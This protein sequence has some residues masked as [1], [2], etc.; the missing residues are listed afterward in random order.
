[1]LA[2]AFPI[3]PNGGTI[4]LKL[5]ITAPLDLVSASEGRLALPAILDRNFS[6]GGGAPHALWIESK[7]PVTT[8]VPGLAAE[9]A[10][11]GAHRLAGT[12]SDGALSATRAI[13]S[14]TRDPAANVRVARIG[15]K[16]EVRQEIATTTATLAALMLVVD[17]SQ[18][19]QSHIAG[20][21]AA[22]EA[23]PAGRPVGL[24][25][26]GDA[27]SLVPVAPWSPTQSEVVRRVLR[28]TDYAGG[29][30]DTDAIIAALRALEPVPGSRIL[31]VHGPQPVSFASSRPRLEQA[32]ARLTRL[33]PLTLYAVE[34][35]PNLLL[36]D[37]PWAWSA[38]MLPAIGGIAA[39][40]AG[41]FTSEL[42]GAERLVVTR[43]TAGGVAENKEEKAAAW[44]G[45][46]RGSE[47][48]ARLWAKDAILAGAL[49]KPSGD[50]T[51][52]VALAAAYRL[53]TPVSGA[54]VLET[55]RQYQVA[56]LTP[57]A[58]GT[59]PTVPEPHEWALLLLAMA[60][61]TII[62]RRRMAGGETG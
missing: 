16:P 4:K 52:A 45:L 10:G 31:W 38:R 3:P 60:T 30:D 49:A 21:I 58:T 59:V 61:L 17:G 46:P 39:D 28:S 23:I 8:R 35:G 43:V 29:A 9:P 44:D 33:A 20:L 19:M 56:G 41:Y 32:T 14:V 22:L 42:G 55:A 40:L 25:V 7:S 26:A 11:A 12:L 62:A 18:R 50:R 1:M 51:E 34:P 6:I 48:I 5:G 2:Q 27:P 47:H 13:V 36:N 24:V 15:D 54:V 37:G 57:V 53:V